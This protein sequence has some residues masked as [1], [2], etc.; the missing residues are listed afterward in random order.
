MGRTMTSS[1]RARENHRAPGPSE[2]TDP[3]GHVAGDALERM[4]AR[5]EVQR[6]CLDFAAERIAGLPGP[7]LELGLGKGRTYDRIR[8]IMPDRDIF[9]FDRELHCPESLT[10]P[11]NRLFLGDF[12][13]TLQSAID[14]FGRIAAMVHADIGSK[15]RAHDVRLARDIG[16]LIEALVRDGGIVL[17]DRQLPLSLG[18]ER[19]PLPSDAARMAWPYYIWTRLQ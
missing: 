4:L 15:D 5:L 19:L 9:V 16:P 14:R 8:R 12:H 7:V 10:P 18:W 13:Q 11:A 2:N 1:G 17:S 3:P 6:A